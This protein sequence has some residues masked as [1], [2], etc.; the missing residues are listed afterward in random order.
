[1]P[2]GHRRRAD[3]GQRPLK[4]AALAVVALVL[5]AAPAAAQ[6]PGA[7]QGEAPPADPP[8]PRLDEQV[9]VTATRGESRLGDA[10]VSLAV[11]PRAALDVSAAPAVDDALRQV[12]GFS[13]FRRSGSRFAN[14][15][16]QGLSLRG[17]GASGASRALVLVDGLPLNDPFGGWVYWGRV[18]ALTLERV[19]VLRGGASDLYGSA[20]L[21]GVVQAVT[22]SPDRGPR[23]LA[24][25][26]GGAL[27]TA[28]AVASAAGQHGA[29]AARVSAQLLRTAGYVAVEPQSRGPV[30]TATGSN[31]AG[32]ELQVE[33]RLAA[34]GRVFARAGVYDEERKN[35]TA[36]QTNDTRLAHGALGADWGEPARGAWSA[37]AWGS[38]E[39]YH[40]SFSAIAAERASEDLVRLQRV[41]ASAFGFS[42]QR[43]QLLGERNEL[44][45]G[46]EAGGVRGTTQETVFSRGAASSR[47]EAGGQA[48]A[49]AAFVQDQLQLRPRLLLSVSLRCDAWSSRDGQSTSA[50][51]PSGPPVVT[52]FGDRS[53]T[54]LS[55]RLGLLFRVSRAV[56]LLGSAYGA[57]RAPTL[58]E[59]YRSFRL[60]DTLTL[61]NPGLRAERLRGGEA[62]TLVTRGKLSLRATAFDARVRDAVANVTVATAPGLTT[63]QRQN[64]ARIGSRGLEAEGE[65][66]LG[67]RAVLSAGYALTDAR[68]RANPSD[69]SLVGLRLPQVPRQQATLQA[70]CASSRWTLSFQG[71]WTS[72]AWDDD[73]NQLA[74]DRALQVDALAARALP[75]GVEL[76]VA[77]ENLLDARIVAARSPVP[78]LAAPRLVRAGLRLRAF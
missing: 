74:L 28:Q 35:G 4:P 19:E 59:L 24:E 68:V 36:L 58:N 11:L 9:T 32:G 40:Q 12:V 5:A 49:A 15:T 55:P 72:A 22:R 45:G 34:S 39:L 23:L 1:M 60:G 64:V 43:R 67:V 53:E 54:A 8:P 2:A 13:L 17:L 33:R 56:A 7:P 20:A 78:S 31:Q 77:A 25:V 21:G 3:P 27:G 37:R 61:S 16:A 50:P 73:R 71:R 51:L 46:V 52:A 76:F 42:A 10:P 26:S 14:P 30:D 18:S 47:V 38:T 48:R 70:R 62:G 57:F 65:L 44:L 66:R 6:A 41:P 69:P 29:W 63:R 75:R